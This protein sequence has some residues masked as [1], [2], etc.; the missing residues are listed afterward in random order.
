ML[1]M[2]LSS[3]FSIYFIFIYMFCL[4]YFAWCVICSVNE[5]GDMKRFRGFMDIIYLVKINYFFIISV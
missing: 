5:I 3:L 1:I 4:C 2:V